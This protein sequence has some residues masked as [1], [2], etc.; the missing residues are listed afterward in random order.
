MID[1]D[2]CGA[3]G[4]I[5]IGRGNIKP[6]PAPP[7][8]PQIALDLNLGSNQGRRGRKPATNRLSYGAAFVIKLLHSIFSIRWGTKIPISHI[9]LK[10][11]FLFY[12]VG[13]PKY[14]VHS[15]MFHPDKTNGNVTSN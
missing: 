12:K 7:C 1:D 15:M 6:A 8:P 5:K 13:Y 3:V 2:E 4:D 10:S 9:S 11:G 14:N